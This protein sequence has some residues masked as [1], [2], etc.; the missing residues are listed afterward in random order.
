MDELEARPLLGHAQDNRSSS[1]A[2]LE[3]LCLR[4]G[5]T[6]SQAEVLRWFFDQRADLD[7]CVYTPALVMQSR[8]V[9][10]RERSIRS[11]VAAWKS[12][13]V[14][15]TIP[16][17]AASGAD[18][19]PHAQLL[20]STVSALAGACDCDR[21][22]KPGGASED[23]SVRGESRGP[24]FP[25]EDLA[26][27]AYVDGPA[28]P[29]TVPAA[30]PFADYR[31]GPDW[32][33]NPSDSQGGTPRIGP[34]AASGGLGAICTPRL[35]FA[36]PVCNLHPP[37]GNLHPPFLPAGGVKTAEKQLT[38]SGVSRLPTEVLACARA[39]S[40]SS[41]NS[42]TDDVVSKQNSVTWGE[43][44]ALANAVRRVVWPGVPPQSSLAALTVHSAA[45]LARS[46][47]SETWIQASAEATR[48]RAENLA[49]KP[50]GDRR[51]Y[52]VGCLRRNCKAI[53]LIAPFADDHHL[54]DWFST[55]MRHVEALVRPRLPELLAGWTVKEQASP[56]QTTPPEERMTREELRELRQ[57][58]RRE[59]G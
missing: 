10:C 29:G 20:W 14:L 12:L 44:R 56:V 5:A 6:D 45:I 51:A 49:A 24:G 36:P 25:D 17:Y 33:T 38:L 55:L 26:P 18:L 23:L 47:L 16:Q 34:D 22:T 21:I 40:V 42:F 57:A 19:P 15:R 52:F 11:A 50:V 9:R 3:R 43:V 53:E 7:P 13:G 27:A 8:W 48:Q 58:V 28:G 31:R 2:T 54:A 4:V 35:Q 32:D 41:D 37:P 30:G 46:V 59:A 39:V 1:L